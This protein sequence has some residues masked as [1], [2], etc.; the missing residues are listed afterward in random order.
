MET[1][2]LVMPGEEDARAIKRT[3]DIVKRNQNQG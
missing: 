2:V 3:V 1:T